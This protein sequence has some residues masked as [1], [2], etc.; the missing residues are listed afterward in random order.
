MLLVVRLALEAQSQALVTLASLLVTLCLVELTYGE[1]STWTLRFQGPLECGPGASSIS[2]PTPDLRGSKVLG[3]A[4]ESVSVALQVT[5]ENV[6]IG[7]PL[8]STRTLYNW[9]N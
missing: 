9:G 7:E 8:K 6:K 3:R 4:Q 1:E 2:R 5:L